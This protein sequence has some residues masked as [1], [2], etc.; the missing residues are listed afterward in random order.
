MKKILIGLLGGVVFV[1]TQAHALSCEVSYKAKKVNT[2]RSIFGEIPNTQYK[3]GKVRGKGSTLGKCK[4]NAL[5]RLKN[6]NW[7]IIYAIEKAY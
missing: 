4:T 5:R 1:S 3:R 2:E 7:R 6:D